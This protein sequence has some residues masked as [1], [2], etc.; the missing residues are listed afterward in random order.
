MKQLASLK[1]KVEKLLAATEASDMPTMIVCQPD[2][3]KVVFGL[4]GRMP[5][6]T[7]PGPHTKMF[8][9]FYADAI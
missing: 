2:G 5:D 9:G 7:P 4:K 6:D 8:A 1:K 3:T